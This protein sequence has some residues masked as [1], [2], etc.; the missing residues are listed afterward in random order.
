[1][2]MRSLITIIVLSISGLAL[3]A[4]ELEDM[5]KLVESGN[6]LFI[7]DRAFPSGGSSVDLLNRPNEVEFSGENARGHLAYF[8]RSHNAASAYTQD[9]GGIR[10]DGE[11][12]KKDIKTKKKKI[13]LSFTMK[14]DRDQYSCFLSISAS[15]SA[16]LSV[17]SNNQSS[18]NYNGVIT[19]KKEEK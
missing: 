6:F 12:M 18:I 1:M 4:Q 11:M 14:G 15:G 7:A 8:G 17:N 13:M 2:K 3:Q 19:P 16:S 5:E 9:G 10:F